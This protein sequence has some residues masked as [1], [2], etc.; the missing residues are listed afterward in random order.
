MNGGASSCAKAGAGEATPLLDLDGFSGPLDRLLALARA[1]AIDL[2]RLPL[3]ALVDQLAAALQQAPPATPLG[4]KGDWVVMVAW[5]VQLR[6]RLLLPADPAPDRVA[7]LAVEPQ[8]A[9]QAAELRDR[10]VDLQAMQTLARWLD[11][12]PRLGR[13]VFARGQPEDFAAAIGV[14][15]DIDVVEFLWASLMLF[16][17]DL[18]DVDTA[19][20]Y[21]PRWRDLHSVPQARLRILRLLAEAPDGRSLARLL[22]GAAE[23]ASSGTQSMLKR[24]SAWT[25]TLVASLELARQGDVQLAQEADFRPILVTRLPVHLTA[26][27]G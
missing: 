2:A 22:P 16:D 8:V 17:D 24:C 6:S 13:D 10:L 19:A 15:H 3:I 9:A 25:S 4:Q 20:G 26:A 14:A 11:S 18:P 7:D 12:R 23:A 1:H 21:R 5:L 27:P